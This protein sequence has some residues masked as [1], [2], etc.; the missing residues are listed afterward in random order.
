MIA[1]GNVFGAFTQVLGTE[2]CLTMTYSVPC[3]NGTQPT[4]IPTY[5]LLYPPVGHSQQIP[6]NALPPPYHLSTTTNSWSPSVI[7]LDGLYVM[8]YTA[9]Q[10]NRSACI[11]EAYSSVPYGPYTD[12]GFLFCSVSTAHGFL[13]PQLFQDTTTGDVYLLFSDQSFGPTGTPCDDGPDSS[14]WI[15]QMSSNGL[16]VT[17]SDTELLTWSQADSIQHLPNLGGS[18]CLENPNIVN[19]P[20]NDYDLLFSI[21]TYNGGTP[22]GSQYVTGEVAC[23][24]LSD[25]ASGCGIN[26]AAG[27]AL[28]NPGGGASTLYTN[29][30]SGNYLMYANYVSGLRNDYVGGPTTDCDPITNNS[31]G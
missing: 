11:G 1:F 22:E 15:V 18:A 26:P 6:T 7:E 3:A 21:G 16:S 29:A 25:A 27:S 12:T 19:D 31:C 23:L 10:S 17:G 30:P 20:N 24:G 14:L 13:D 8:A 2:S 28:I 5:T 4:N 9:I